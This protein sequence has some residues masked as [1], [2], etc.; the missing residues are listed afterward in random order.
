MFGTFLM[1]ILLVLMRRR[2]VHHRRLEG[3]SQHQDHLK[4]ILLVCRV[5][6]SVLATA[7]IF[8]YEQ[9][10]FFDQTRGTKAVPRT[11]V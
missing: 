3:L 4:T 8:T 6:V 5:A 9:S 1:V 2:I 10:L 7:V 11:A